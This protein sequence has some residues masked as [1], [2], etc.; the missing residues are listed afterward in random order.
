MIRTLKYFSWDFEG[1]NQIIG[2]KPKT[3]NFS[4]YPGILFSGDDFYLLN[5]KVGILQTTL[6]V[7]NKFVYKDLIEIKNYIPEFM[8]IQ[9]V[10]F[11]SYSG[12]DWMNNY[13]NR[14][15]HMYITQWLVID[16]NLLAKLNKG[17]NVDSK[18]LY[19]VEE[20]PK[21]I[22]TK[23]ITKELLEKK[24]YGSFNLSYFPEHQDLLGISHYKN[25]N[26]FSKEYNPRHYI[27]E[28]LEGEINN[29]D[30]FTKVLLYNGF[31]SHHPILMNDPSLNNASNGISAREDLG[32][33][34]LHGGVDFKV[35][36]FYFI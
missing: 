36:S 11:I 18:L 1:E 9:I 25:V 20:A 2:M 12:E 23:D 17:Q 15:N 24:Y 32:G 4:S 22:L 34:S 33:G 7:I 21:S 28:N 27:L 3:I 31:H 29:I 5:S 35:N 26:F 16:Y 10:N 19:L 13:K 14:K 6:S 30:E 8:R